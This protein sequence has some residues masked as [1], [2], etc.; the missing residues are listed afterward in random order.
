MAKKDKQKKGKNQ[1]DA[2]M[3]INTAGVVP[4]VGGVNSTGMYP[5]PVGGVNSTGM[6]PPPVGGVNSTGMY[7]PPVGGVNSTGMFP[8]PVGGVNST[9]MYPGMVAGQQTF[10]QQ[11]YSTGVVGATPPPVAPA[12]DGKGKK[13]KEK[14]QKAGKKNKHAVSRNVDVSKFNAEQMAQYQLDEALQE[15]FDPSSRLRKLKSPL[16][17]G[18]CLIMLAVFVLVTLIAVFIVC[19]IMVDKFNPI[20][21]AAD[22]LEKFG[23]SPFFRWLFGRIKSLFGGGG[24]EAVKALL[25]LLKL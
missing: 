5:P 23:I 14:K 11:T 7:P 15:S 1:P 4:P 6:Y 9:G 17:V 16:S 19:W 3:N 18:G 12:T 13:V 24:S 25:M 20:T 21:I 22:M 2:A 8:P 10:T